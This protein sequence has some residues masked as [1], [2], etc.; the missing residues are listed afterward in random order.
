MEIVQFVFHEP[1]SD[2]V[3]RAVRA[4][5]RSASTST[6]CMLHLRPLARTSKLWVQKCSHIDGKWNVNHFNCKDISII[7]DFHL[8]GLFF[9]LNNFR[10]KHLK[11]LNYF[12]TACV[13]DIR[14]LRVIVLMNFH[15]RLYRCIFS[16]TINN[17]IY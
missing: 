3:H 9:C 8:F 13:F 17:T 2:H 4:L 14:I 16:I 11:L 15:W 1:M 12:A 7:S 10:R 6:A 5:S